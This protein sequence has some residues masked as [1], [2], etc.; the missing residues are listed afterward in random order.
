MNWYDKQ[1]ARRAS[2]ARFDRDERTRRRLDETPPVEPSPEILP[3]SAEELAEEAAAEERRIARLP[4][5]QRMSRE[6]RDERDAILA[7]SRYLST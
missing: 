2:A 3:P 4:W 5:E 6:E 7:R 1:R